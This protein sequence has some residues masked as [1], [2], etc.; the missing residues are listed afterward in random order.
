MS[1]EEPRPAQRLPLRCETCAIVAPGKASACTFQHARASAGEALLQPEERPRKIVYLRR[2]H[3][4]LESGAAVTGASFPAV[5]G[6]SSLLG[7]ESIAGEDISYTARAL[8]DVA[9]CTTDVDTFRASLGSLES[10]LGTALLFALRES[11]KRANERLAV[12]GT[13]SQRVARFLLQAA[14]NGEAEDVPQ[15]VVARILG[16]RAETL[17]R[18]LAELRRRGALH[19]GRKIRLRDADRLR[20]IAE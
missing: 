11:A 5:R 3:A 7:L 20:A 18:T 15:R 6:P 9:V 16:M 8:T 1:R 13:A 12:E 17:S 14:S 4:V 2:G 19:D 10:P